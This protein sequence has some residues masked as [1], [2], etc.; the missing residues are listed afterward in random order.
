MA[1]NNLSMYYMSEV[2]M[3]DPDQGVVQLGRFCIKFVD[4]DTRDKFFDQ[5]LIDQLNNSVI[6][7]MVVKYPTF[8][9][10]EYD[11][12]IEYVETGNVTP[13]F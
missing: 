11:P 7:A 1:T 6:D 8:L 4:S 3:V 5:F 2:L 13:T 9:T 12:V 10:T